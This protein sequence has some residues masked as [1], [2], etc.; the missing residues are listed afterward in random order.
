MMQEDPMMMGEEDPMMEGPDEDTSFKSDKTRYYAKIDQYKGEVIEP[1]SFNCCFVFSLYVLAI[2]AGLLQGYQVGIIAGLE[3]FVKDEYRDINQKVESR[4]R[5]LFVSLFSLGAAFGSL[6]AGEISDAIGRKWI[7]LL[8]D[9]LVGAG[10][11]VIVFSKKVWVGYIGR[12]VSGF[13]SG[14]LSFVIPVYLGEV[15]PP[16]W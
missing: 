2:T 4:E 8:G 5:E 12:I 3:L 15:G 16:K 1:P 13:G 10:F 6:F 14:F 9:T 7:I 11:I